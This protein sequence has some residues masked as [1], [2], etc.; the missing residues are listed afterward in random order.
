MDMRKLS[1]KF[2]VMIDQKYNKDCKHIFIIP[3]EITAMVAYEYINE[4]GLSK[5]SVEIIFIRGLNSNLFSLMNVTSS[6]RGIFEKIGDRYH[7]NYLSYNSKIR[8][9]A[10]SF[11]KDFILYVTWFNSLTAEIIKSKKCIAHVYLEEGEL[12]YR[13]IPLRRDYLKKC[14][15][16]A[17]DYSFRSDAIL[18]I[19]ITKDSFPRIP[20]E[21]KYILK[22]FEYV[23][24][25]Y[26]PLLKNYNTI[27]I[28]PTPARLPKSEWKNTLIK[29]ASHTSEPFALKLHPGFENNLK[30]YKYFRKILGELGYANS[31]I[32]SKDVILEAEM[33]FSKKKLIGDRSS[34]SRYA[35]LLGSEFKKI[36]FLSDPWSTYL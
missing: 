26:S 35:N 32:V 6:T 3:N 21:K 17:K 33:L 28:M 10:D 23:K 8:R 34:L 24:K 7:I 12:A 31:V 30:V 36:N 20:K 29:L 27:L 1:K 18:W 22:S 2:V 16:N 9:I 15:P 14:S 4:V 11:K 5:D 13:N 19:G 25:H